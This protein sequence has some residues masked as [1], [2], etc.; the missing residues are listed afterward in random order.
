MKLEI[1]IFRTEISIFRT[2]KNTCRECVGGELEPQ[3]AI[4]TDKKKLYNKKINI[5]N[6]F[7]LDCSYMHVC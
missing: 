4:R 1:S 6:V 2:N 7:V 3:P 5:D